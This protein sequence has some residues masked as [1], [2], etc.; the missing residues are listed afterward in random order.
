MS[1]DFKVVVRFARNKDGPRIGEMQAAEFVG[2]DV[3][4]LTDV[5]W[6]KVDN[7]LVAEVEKKIVGCLQLCHGRP[8]GYTELLCVD[9]NFPASVIVSAVDNLIGR[10]HLELIKAGSQSMMGC[11]PMAAALNFLGMGKIEVPGKVPPGAKVH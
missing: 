8:I 3:P 4:Q 11:A 9:R 10:A 1:D 2:W 6:S 7:W 5:D